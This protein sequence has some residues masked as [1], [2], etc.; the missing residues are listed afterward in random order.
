MLLKHF[1]FQNY[2]H[3]SLELK[4]INIKHLLLA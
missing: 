4:R 2:Q 1:I 3:V